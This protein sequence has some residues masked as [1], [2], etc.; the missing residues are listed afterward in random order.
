MKDETVVV[1]GYPGLWRKTKAYGMY[2]SG[3]LDR[4]RKLN[5]QKYIA[6]CIFILRYQEERTG[7]SV[8]WDAQFARV[9]NSLKTFTPKLFWRHDLRR[10]DRAAY[11]FLEQVL[12]SENSLKSAAG[13]PNNSL[14]NEEKNRSAELHYHRLGRQLLVSALNEFHS[15]LTD[16]S[17]YTILEHNPLRANSSTRARRV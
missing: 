3:K 6:S 16:E 7:M 10:L 13:M 2:S 4:D 1:I 12:I 8:N 14:E 17:F 11:L 5:A 15:M 9:D